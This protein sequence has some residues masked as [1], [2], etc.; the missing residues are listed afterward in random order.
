MVA[1]NEVPVTLGPFIIGWPSG[2]STLGPL[3][4]A[5][6]H[7]AAGGDAVWYACAGIGAVLGAGFAALRT[8]TVTES[9]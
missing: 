4:A 8:P 7:G 6:L 9:P 1:V 5:G 3:L 2:A